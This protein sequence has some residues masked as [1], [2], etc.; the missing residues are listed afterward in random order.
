[1][2]KHQ[3][4]LVCIKPAEIMFLE[5]SKLVEQ[6]TTIDYSCLNNLIDAIEKW[7]LKKEK[8]YVNVETPERRTLSSILNR[9]GVAGAAL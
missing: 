7:N 9:P 6:D 8:K 2:N 1:M 4:G 3:S 5:R